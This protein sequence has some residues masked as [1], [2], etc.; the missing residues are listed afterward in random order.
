MGHFPF[1]SFPSHCRAMVKL[2]KIAPELVNTRLTNGN[3]L[4]P[5]HFTAICN[6]LKVAKVIVEQVRPF[7]VR[8]F[9]F[10]FS[11]NLMPSTNESTKDI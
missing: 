9:S 3:G 8:N 10:L 11:Q 4:A 6:H 1:L 5:L 2:L 7:T